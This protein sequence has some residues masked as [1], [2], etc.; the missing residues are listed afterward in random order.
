MLE[1]ERYIIIRCPKC[2]KNVCG[3]VRD[4]YD[5]IDND[6]L[7]NKGFIIMHKDINDIRLGICKCTEEERNL[8][9]NEHEKALSNNMWN[10]ENYRKLF[11]E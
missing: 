11:L 7:T 4:F 8:F 1:D 2:G 10:V 9:I 3:L 6:I 5:I